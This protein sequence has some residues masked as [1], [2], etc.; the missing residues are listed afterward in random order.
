MDDSSTE[1]SSLASSNAARVPLEPRSFG[2]TAD[3]A[4]PV[5][6][7]DTAEEV[8]SAGAA[9]QETDKT[10]GSLYSDNQTS[11]PYGQSMSVGGSDANEVRDS[12]AAVAADGFPDDFAAIAPG[13]MK[14]V[15][16]GRPFHISVAPS[17]D[18]KSIASKVTRDCPLL[19]TRF[20]PSFLLAFSSLL[21]RRLNQ[22]PGQSLRENW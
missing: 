16:K 8:C 18:V 15:L 6:P 3:A 20:M 17:D 5:M 9:R 11:A 7:C 2:T 13:V 21:S 10:S 1:S 22:R 12:G 14:I 19:S 4:P